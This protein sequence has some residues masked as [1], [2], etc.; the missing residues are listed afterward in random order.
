MGMEWFSGVDITVEVSFTTAPLETPVWVDITAH[1]RNIS[2]SRGKQSE[3]AKFAP[4]RMTVKLDNRG[5][6]F[7]PAYTPGPFFGDL[8]P[9]KRIRAVAGFGTAEYP[10]FDGFVLAWP[11]TFP[12]KT[13]SVVTIECMD[14][15]RILENSGLQRTAY[16]GAVMA[17][18]P[19]A[20]WPLQ[21]NDTSVSAVFADIVD[22][23]DIAVQHDAYSQSVGYPG[24]DYVDETAPV[25]GSSA[26]FTID[27][28]SRAAPVAGIPYGL[29]FW[30]WMERNQTLTEPNI[31]VRGPV[32]SGDQSWIQ[33]RPSFGGGSTWLDVV[34][35]NTDDDVG[36][37]VGDTGFMLPVGLSHFA[38]WYDGSDILVYINSSLV[39]TLPLPSSASPEAAGAPVLL[40]QNGDVTLD[41]DGQVEN[42]SP[43]SRLSHVAV[44]GAGT[45]PDWEKHYLA[46]ITAFGHPFAERSGAR[47]DRVL[48]EIGW[49]DDLRDI[50]VGDTVHG[51]YLAGRASA[52]T[53]LRDV[54]TAEDGYVFVSADGKV[55]L[56][57]RQWI[58][59]TSARHLV[60]DDDGEPVI[61]EDT[62]EQVTTLDPPV[63][64]CDGPMKFADITIDS[65]SVDVI[66]NIIPVDYGDDGKQIR[67][68]DNSS[69]EA[70]GPAEEPISIP[71]VDR[72]DVARNLA[73]YRLSEWKDPRTR[74]TRLLV[75][76]RSRPLTFHTV[77]GFDLGARARAEIAPLGI[78]DPIV[79]E[80]NVEGIEH[81]ITPR[82]E[83]VTNLYCTPAVETAFEAPYFIV[84]DP[85]YGVTG[86]A[87]GNKIPF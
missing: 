78:G 10:L 51:P 6:Q 13:D 44:Y 68:K 39:A 80:V 18:N 86:A 85:V 60:F 58:W 72:S 52:L 3:F 67:V 15:Y 25:G 19:I 5:R 65:H 21:E 81:D 62:S 23:Q 2:T 27:Q 71:T 31:L 87:A 32:V 43:F 30:V 24:P 77:L 59:M 38:L 16:E 73:D 64:S 41:G 37:G 69:V 54:E 66:R 28:V 79:Q 29:E 11:M 45:E 75:W 47:I 63:F 36:R 34:F 49:P 50:A 33:V 70:Y 4:G 76:P 7:D 35:S 8:N 17:D 26:M 82:G 1:V 61:D 83:W 56:R 53:Y 57:D 46:G 9:M 55:T 84:G 14:G 40:H 48:D 74:I 20:Y 12:G 42:I 22:G